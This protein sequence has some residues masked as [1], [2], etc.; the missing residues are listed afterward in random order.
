MG[1]PMRSGQNANP[2]SNDNI[3]ASQLQGHTGTIVECSTCHGSAMNNQNTLGGPHGMHP[4]GDNT[5]F[6]NG[7]HEHMGTSGC[8]ACHG[9][10]GRSSNTGTVL[11]LA[12][13]DR[14][15]RGTLV[16]KGEPVGCS[17]CHGGGGGGD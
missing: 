5:S 11:S 2:N 8:S 3:T 6:A 10:G 16:A 7:G 17:V 1:R 13:A 4:V 15:L 9:P 12:K 14:N